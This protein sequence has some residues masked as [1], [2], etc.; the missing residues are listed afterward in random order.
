MEKLIGREI[1]QQKLTKYMQSERGEFIAIYGR[2]RV[3]KTF[4]VRSFFKDKFAFYATGIIEGTREEEME[5]FYNG[6]KEYGYEGDQPKTW[7]AMFSALSELLQ[8]KSQRTKKRLV[9]FID[10]LPCFDTKRSGFIHALDYFWNSKGAWMD[11]VMFVVCGSA[12]SWMMRNLINN[13]G[14]LHNRLTHQMHVR[15]FTL[16]ETERYLR[17][18]KFRWSRLSILQAY[19]AL[20]GVPYYLGLL[21]PD[22]QMPENLDNLFFAENSELKGEYRRLFASLYKTPEAYMR[23]VETLAAHKEGYTREEIA[24][25][26]KIANN[27]HLTVM[28]EDLV[29]CDFLREYSDGGKQ[30]GSIYQLMD[31]FTLFHYSFCRKRVTDPHF[32]RNLEGLPVQNIFYGLAFER[33]CMWHVRQIVQAL[34]LDAVPH[35][36]YAW[37]SKESNPAVQIDLIIERTDMITLFEIKYCK[38]IYRLNKTEYQKIVLREQSFIS[39][40]KSKRHGVRTH[41]IST[42]GVA[43]G[44][45][46]DAFQSKVCLDDLFKPLYDI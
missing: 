44:E 43:P 1:E 14:G 31:M 26:L 35:E 24:D 45:Y 2:R 32:W 16:E 33:V 38:D 37:R 23:I 42:F 4:L 20:G 40:L 11:N 18:R 5:A 29:S 28:L 10:E 25:K 17:S 8:K 27:G 34:R 22:M 7:M 3:G 19:M 13:K 21:E 41:I 36:Y 12:T 30:K 9:V 46:A 15:Q 6:L 39:E